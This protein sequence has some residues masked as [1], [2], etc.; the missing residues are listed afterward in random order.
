MCTCRAFFCSFCISIHNESLM[1][2]LYVHMLLFWC[3]IVLRSF[4]CVLCVHY[5]LLLHVAPDCTFIM[6]L[7]DVYGCLFCVVFERTV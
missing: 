1:V 5:H 3:I 2:E 6:P 7:F 4:G